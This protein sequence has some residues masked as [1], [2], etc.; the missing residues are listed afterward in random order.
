MSMWS[1]NRDIQCGDNY[2]DT[3]VV[4]DS[5]SGVKQD[6]LAFTTTLSKGFNGKL[7]ENASV[8]TAAEPQSN[9]QPTDDP[10]TSPYQIWQEQGVY[11]P[12]TKVVWHRNVYQAKWW[13]QGD[14]PDNPVLQAWQTP[15]QLLGPVLPGEKP[16]PQPTLPPGTFPDWSGTAEYNAGDRVLLDG[17]PYQAKWWTKGDSP[18]ASSVNPDNSPWAALSQTQFDSILKES[19]QSAKPKT[20]AY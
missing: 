13:T 9:I 8:V 7:Y 5:C 12:Q 3:K 14:I 19:T 2:V 4:S 20:S 1:E 10:A 15:W 6:K 11:L 17:I 16:V 18:A